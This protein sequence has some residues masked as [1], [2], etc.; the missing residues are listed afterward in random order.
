MY[1]TIVSV[2]SH[3]KLSPA[4]ALFDYFEHGLGQV[5][6]ET[7]ATISLNP[8]LISAKI[9]HSRKKKLSGSR[10]DIQETKMRIIQP[11]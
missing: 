7:K 3:D 1:P 8:C 6:P 2:R 5:L 10:V 4:F 11:F 9:N